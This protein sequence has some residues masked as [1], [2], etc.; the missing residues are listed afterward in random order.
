MLGGDFPVGVLRWGVWLCWGGSCWELWCWSEGVGL[1]CVFVGVYG[2]E[3]VGVLKWSV[4]FFLDI[5]LGSRWNG[6]Y[7][8]WSKRCWD[9]DVQVGCVFVGVWGGGVR[10]LKWGVWLLG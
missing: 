5:M 9:E 7:S 6:W 10:V 4:Y 3:V 8:K 2:V 1:E